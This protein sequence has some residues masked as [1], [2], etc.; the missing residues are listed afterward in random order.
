MAGTL[1]L[2][3]GE[4]RMSSWTA[5]QH[6][7]PR[8]TEPGT[9]FYC[10]IGTPVYAPES[11]R[12]YGYGESIVPATGRWVGIDFDN[13]M[14]FRAMHFSRIALSQ[15]VLK[16]RGFVRKGDLIAYSGASGYGVEDWSG[17][18]NTGGSHTHV[19]LWPTHESKFGYRPNGTPYTVDFMNYVSG[20]SGGAGTGDD[21]S[22]E[23]IYNAR[24][25][26]PS[27]GANRNAL[28][29]GIQTRADIANFRNYVAD[30]FS[31]MPN[32]VWK[33]SIPAQDGKGNPLLID[34]KPVLFSASGF[35]ASTNAAVSGKVADVDEVALAQ[36]LAPLITQN[37]SALS[38]EDIAKIAKATADEQARRLAT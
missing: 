26:D 24:A 29:F 22:V 19:T 9:D 38:T 27:D 31:K 13:G 8:S 33:Y 20:S 18:P 15:A 10:P 2:P 25:T 5:H 32:E 17:N 11:G 35:V 36:A 37:L 16:N 1:L 7:N 28:D 23:D 6:R 3:V 30:M 12:V 4:R 34:G 14:R 21:M